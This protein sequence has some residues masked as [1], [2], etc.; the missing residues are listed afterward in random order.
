MVLDGF[1]L[2]EQLSGKQNGTRNE[3]F[4]NHFPHGMHRSK[5]FTSL[6]KDNWKII[7]HYPIVNEEPKYELFNLKKDPFEVENLA[8]KNPEKLKELMTTLSKG[9]K[10]MNAKYPEKDGEIL[11][12]MIPE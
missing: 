11:K 7:Y 5:Y 12:L 10:N 6:V 9:M 2:K 3:E 8:E 1:N 4:L